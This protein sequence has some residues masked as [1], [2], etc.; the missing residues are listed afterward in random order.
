MHSLGLSIKENYFQIMT[1][2]FYFGGIICEE[3]KFGEF[4]IDFLELDLNHIA[5]TINT[6]V[7]DIEEYL[8]NCQITLSKKYDLIL[9]RLLL[10]TIE[11]IL[12]TSQDRS[13]DAQ[14][15]YENLNAYFQSVAL[16]QI[17]AEQYADG[18]FDNHKL[19]Q[20][21]P[22]MQSISV[23]FLYEKD[24]SCLE[25]VF[26]IK[27]IFSLIALEISKLMEKNVIIKKCENCKKYFIPEKRSDEIYCN[28]IFKNNKTCKE[29]GYDE[30]I[31]K[32]AFAKAYR[33][34]YKTQHQRIRYNKHIDGY[35]QKHFE[36]WKAA[37][38]KALKKFQQDDDIKGFE[39]WLH[40][41]RNSF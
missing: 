41:H 8:E 11:E 13:F 28:R 16:L 32:D 10:N 4:L 31:S 12:S 9:I 24:L 15:T 39:N 17:I 29:I 3:Y 21:L 2:P 25:L 30:K 33:K 6:N 26:T 19:C 5:D 22:L 7:F 14:K 1:N 18:H 40:D 27:D 38:K 23:N 35:A 37:A 20:I 34:E 36:P